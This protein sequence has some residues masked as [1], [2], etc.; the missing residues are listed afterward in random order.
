MFGKTATVGPKCVLLSI[1]ANISTINVHLIFASVGF[2]D[3]KQ[4]I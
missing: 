4:I 1:T 3:Q 2:K